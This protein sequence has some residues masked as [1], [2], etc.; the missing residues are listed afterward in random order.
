MFDIGDLQCRRA[1][2]S[3]APGLLIECNGNG[4]VNEG[5]MAFFRMKAMRKYKGG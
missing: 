1:G 4:W 3:A 5:W 2:N